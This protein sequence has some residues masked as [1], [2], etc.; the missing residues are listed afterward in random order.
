VID[1]RA[2]FSFHA[3]RSLRTPSSA[4]GR[5]GRSARGKETRSPSRRPSP[6]CATRIRDSSTRRT[7]DYAKR[8]TQ[9]SR[10]I[11]SLL[12]EHSTKTRRIVLYGKFQ[13]ERQT[14][15]D[16]YFSLGRREQRGHSFRRHVLALIRESFTLR[17]KVSPC[18]TPTAFVPDPAGPIKSSFRATGAARTPVLFREPYTRA[19]AHV[20]ILFLF[21]S[22]DNLSASALFLLSSRVQAGRRR[23]SAPGH[24]RIAGC[25]TGSNAVDVMSNTNGLA[26]NTFFHPHAAVGNSAWPRSASNVQSRR[27][28][29]FHAPMEKEEDAS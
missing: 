22:S 10:R 9:S 12:G 14:R 20:Y 27:A 8:I 1:K 7:R 21:L 26:E 19:R 11:S 24:S 15:G 18:A 4:K 29:S 16:S 23:I 28:I 2:A 17:G 5:N 13:G 3:R 6:S 25:N